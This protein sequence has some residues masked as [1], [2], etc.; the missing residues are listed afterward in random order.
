MVF[1]RSFDPRCKNDMKSGGKDQLWLWV[2][3]ITVTA[4][5]A[6]SRRVSNFST[7]IFKQ[8]QNK[9]KYN[10]EDHM[11]NMWQHKHMTRTEQTED[12]IYSTWENTRR[13]KG[14]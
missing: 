2:V 3:H 8:K 6:K 1:E 4:G 12:Y 5:Q 7:F 13:E 14:N 11:K 10:E 9:K